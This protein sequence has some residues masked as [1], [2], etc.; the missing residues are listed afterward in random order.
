PILITSDGHH[1]SLPSCPTRRSSDL[2]ASEPLIPEQER[3]VRARRDPR[4]NPTAARAQR[5]AARGRE[6]SAQEREP[7][8]TA[9]AGDSIAR[10]AD[11][12]STRL[13]SSHDQ[14]SYAVFCLK[15]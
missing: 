7:E 11:R 5:Q 12:K 9:K 2:G 3:L 1:R 10:I 15:K 6:S 8:E 13:N 14:I 4:G